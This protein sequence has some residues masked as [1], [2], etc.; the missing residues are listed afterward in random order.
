MLS[1]TAII[2][3]LFL[4]PL[5]VLIIYHDVRY[6]RIPNAFVLATLISGLTLNFALAGLS[7]ALQ[8]VGGCVLAF[9][10]MF[11][12]HVF[13][14][15]GAGDVKLFAAVGSLMGANLVLPTFVIVI[16]TGGLLA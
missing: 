5:A 3:E 16:L 4:V 15:M 13:G 12:L 8:S 11:I 6:R 10:L 2:V 14:A 1:P 7:G 9:I